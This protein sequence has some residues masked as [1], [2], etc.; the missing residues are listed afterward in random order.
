MKDCPTSR[1]LSLT[2]SIILSFSHS[3]IL[4]LTKPRTQILKIDI[5]L[6][7]VGDGVAVEEIVDGFVEFL[8]HW[9]GA[10]DL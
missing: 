4:S 6:Q 5:S 10:A 3:L 8:P 1:I 9:Q 7:K 2:H